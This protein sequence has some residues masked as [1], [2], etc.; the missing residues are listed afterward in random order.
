M[1]L[2][3]APRR[4]LFLGA[5][6]A[7]TPGAALAWPGV[8]V[9]AVELLPEVVDVAPWFASASGYGDWPERMRLVV[10]DARRWVRAASGSWDVVVGDLF[11]PARDGAAGLFTREQFQAIREQLAPG[12]LCCQWL[13]LHQLQ[14]AALRSVLRTFLAVFP[15]ARAWWLRWDVRAPVLGLV[16]AVTP[17]RY[18]LGPSGA[19]PRPEE[20]RAALREAG[21]DS[22]T[23]RL[24]RFAGGV[25]LLQRWAGEAP[26]NTDDHP[27]VGF[28][29]PRRTARLRAAPFQPL[30]E[31]LALGPV[32]G[33]DLLPPDTPPAERERLVALWAARDAFLRGLLAEAKGDR[34][35]AV[36]EWVESARLSPDFTTGYARCLTLAMGWAQ[37]RPA[38]TAALLRRLEQARP[39]N[40][41]AARLRQRL[42]PE[43]E[44]Q[45]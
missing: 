22:A 37:E 26:L 21:L 31:W 12:G 38:A 11:H 7:I 25:D 8:E 23:A 10:G 33:K 29:A 32:N 41:V 3:P 17:R 36:T 14:G 24:A 5:G 2:H 19:V 1:L 15:E 27:V 35:S 9:T 34:E 39:E 6:T 42:F 16:G 30:A 28:L 13:P 18:G 44:P 20:T 43:A 4:A 40:P 45:P